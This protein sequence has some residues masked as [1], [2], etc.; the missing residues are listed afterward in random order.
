[1]CHDTAPHSLGID[2]DNALTGNVAPGFGTRAPHDFL[3]HSLAAADAT[4]F[5]DGRSQP[6][7]GARLRLHH[8]PM[9]V[10]K[11]HP[12]GDMVVATALRSG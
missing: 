8:V 5:V 7:L 10:T 12:F 2:V 9:G 11:L 3:S 4:L 1:M 6:S